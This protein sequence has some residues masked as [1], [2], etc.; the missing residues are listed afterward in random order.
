MTAVEHRVSYPCGLSSEQKLRG[1]RVG[2][3]I[4]SSYDRPHLSNCPMHGRTCPTH[5]DEPVRRALRELHS[6]MYE[7]NADDL[8]L[9][10]EAVVEHAL[11]PV[12]IEAP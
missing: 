10:L 5:Y 7:L 12:R 8:Y 6:Q 2:R 9:A 1:W 4:A 11:G 3:L